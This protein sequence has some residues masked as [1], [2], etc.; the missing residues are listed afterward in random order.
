MDSSSRLVTLPATLA[1]GVLLGLPGPGRDRLAAQAVDSAHADSASL[2]KQAHDRQRDFE[3]FRASHIPLTPL[4]GDGRCDQLIGRIC[5]WFGGEDE[6]DFPPE[7]SE[8]TMARDELVRTLSGIASQIQDP[9]VTGELVRYYLEE[10]QA[11]EAEQIARDCR[12]TERWW[13]DALLGYVLQIRGSFVDAETAFRMAIDSMPSEERER[14]TTPGYLLTEKGD[15]VFA[16]SAPAARARLWS[17]FWRLSDPLYLVPGNDRLT[18]HYARLVEATLDKDAASPQAMEWNKD[19]DEALIRY[20]RM[21]GW[22]RSRT[23]PVGMPGGH[24][25]ITDTREVIGHHAPGSRGYLFPEE[26]LKAPADVPPESWITAPRKAHTWYAPPYAPDFTELETQVGRF[27]RGDE[28]LVVGA[29]QPAEPEPAAQESDKPRFEFGRGRPATFNPFDRRRPERKQAETDT[30]S[31]KPVKIEGP[32]ESGLYLVPVDGGQALDTLGDAPEGVFTMEV[33]QGRYVS[34]MELYEPG[35]KRAWRAR[36]GLVQAPLTPGLAAVSDLLILKAGASLP[37]SL[38]EAIPE[39]RP[40][41]RIHQGERFIVVWEVYG[42][43]IQ[44]RIGVTLGFTKGRPGFL[45]RVG[46]FVGILKP[47]QPV[48]VTFQ[49]TGPA[50]VHTAF[51]AVQVQ[52]PKL[53]P[54]AYTLHL[55]LDLAGREPVVTSRP[56]TV[57]PQ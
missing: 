47:E 32:V 35:A 22:S 2:V 1:V 55:R 24:L 3:A 5:I 26:F 21:I 56:I 10:G 51:R 27:R 36:Q 4:P 50:A 54:G 28:M 9:W 18:E 11:S 48:D 7:L 14:W 30:A 38:D 31:P 42:L 43:Q 44:E 6:E 39:V 52:L 49:D 34:S 13:C 53:D 57:V 33:P 41:V 23:R 25:D 40:G 20:G 15:E 12:L 46:R 45:Q 37:T 16:D 17:L 8:T 29:Y 19:E